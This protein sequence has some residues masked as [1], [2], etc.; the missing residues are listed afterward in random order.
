M[1]TKTLFWITV[2]WGMALVW[3]A[4]HPPMIDLPQHAAQVSL[5][6]DLLA[7]RSSWAD[8][9]QIN[10][11][12]PYLVGYG[13]SLLLSCFMPTLIAIKLLLSLTFL[14][15]VVVGIQARRYFDADARLD[16][17]LIP[18][19]FGFAFK[20]GFLTFLVAAPLCM[21]FIVLC[22]RHARLPNWRGG[23]LVVVTGLVLLA[24]HGLVF[25][26]GWL[27][28]MGMVIVRWER[29]MRWIGRCLPLAITAMA[30]LLYFY[31]SRRLEARLGVPVHFDSSQHWSW[32]RPLQAL[33]YV[34]DNDI[35]PYF[36]IPA[37][38]LLA[39]PWMMGLTIGRQQVAACIPLAIVLGIFAVVPT[40]ALKT[41]FLYQRFA[42]FLLP[43]YA[44][45]FRSQMTCVSPVSE[46]Q[47][48]MRT[49]SVIV[50]IAAIW[51]TL[52]FHTVHAWRFRLESADFEAVQNAV[53]PEQRALYL[54]FDAD[55]VAD[56]HVNMYRHFAAWYQ[57]EQR[58]FVDFNFA[59][60][61]PQIARFRKNNFPAADQ[62]LLWAPETFDWQAHNGSSYRYFF[63]RGN[64]STE[65]S[66][67][68]NAPCTPRKIAAKGMWSVYE[69]ASCK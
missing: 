31:I 6:Q 12:T 43:A 46:M 57:A 69:R 52:G 21:A 44:W 32:S 55:S 26:F 4:H 30:C 64:S 22:D 60:F 15:F 27:A 66:V 65:A 9:V 10:L 37:V 41:A 53:E 7:G 40:A 1:R 35:R 54:A 19:C 20:W 62:K 68:Q 51:F 13:V 36:A 3:V 45:S 2:A 56:D 61:P 38:A 63:L 18:G 29:S 14:A 24:S 42:I 59:W 50:M 47:R 49:S 16:W 67:F 25:A 34:F 23:A 11:L 5:L 58:G 33:F 28:G 17:L 39:A 48:W 8:V